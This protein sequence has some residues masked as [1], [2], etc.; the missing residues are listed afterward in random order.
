MDRSVSVSGE[1][2]RYTNVGGETNMCFGVNGRINLA[3]SVTGVKSIGE[4][5]SFGGRGAGGITW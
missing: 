1:I 3:I 4:P 2:D 5:P